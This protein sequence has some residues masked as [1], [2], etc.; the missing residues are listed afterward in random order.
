MNLYN[1]INIQ[2]NTMN[3]IYSKIYNNINDNIN[4]SLSRKKYT[5][6]FIIEERKCYKFIE[7]VK[8]LFA[9][10]CA[11]NN[12]INS[13]ETL[14][15]F[16]RENSN[17]SIPQ[18]VKNLLLNYTSLQYDFGFDFTYNKEIIDNV[19]YPWNVNLVDIALAYMKNNIDDKHF[20]SFFEQLKKSKSLIDEEI[21]Y[22][23]EIFEGSAKWQEYADI[24]IK[25]FEKVIRVVGNFNNMRLTYNFLCKKWIKENNYTFFNKKLNKEL[26]P[27]YSNINLNIKSISDIQGLHYKI[28]EINNK[29]IVSFESNNWEAIGVDP[30]AQ[31]LPK[32]GLKN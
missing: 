19:G 5:L 9:I 27:F 1:D 13:V 28:D 26:V 31:F 8:E 7:K 6:D 12:N 30:D 15:N 29:I 16:I 10:N 25:K 2:L 23:Y 20:D 14:N 24:T 18:Y 32:L 11:F 3:D 21:A 22:A 4:V 17:N